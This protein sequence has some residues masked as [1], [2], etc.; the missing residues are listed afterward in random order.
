[1]GGDML[2]RWGNPAN[3]GISGQQV[4]PNAVHDSRWIINDGRPNGGYLQI[5]NNSGNGSGQSTIDGIETPLD[6]ITGY[7]Y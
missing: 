1:M 6:P 3:Y 4:I 5:F 2:Y 7:T